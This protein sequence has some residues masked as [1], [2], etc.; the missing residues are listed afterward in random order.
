M[1]TSFLSED[2][3]TDD[4]VIS[5]QKLME[6]S[7]EQLANFADCFNSQEIKQASMKSVYTPILRQKINALSITCQVSPDEMWEIFSLVRTIFRYLYLN[8]D[9]TSDFVQD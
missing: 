4:Q 1:K 6:F 5:L 2:N 8:E 3:L 7:D 9:T